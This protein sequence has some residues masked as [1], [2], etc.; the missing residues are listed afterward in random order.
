MDFSITGLSELERDMKRAIN[1]SPEAAKDTLKSL[2]K[3]FLK[4][5]KK[6]AK[7]ELKKHKRSGD[8][9]KKAIAKKWGSK[10][11]GDR[12]GMTALIWNSAR[13]FHLIENGH[14]LVRGGKIIGFVTG[15]RIMARTKQEFES[16]MPDE[17]EKM[18]D[19]VLKESN[20]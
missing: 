18:I 3:D 20:L 19:A 10:V 13:H 17:I 9:Q 8:Q 14:N 5:A 1:K 12:L 4:S 7:A 2:K 11:I 15:K 16:I 6:R